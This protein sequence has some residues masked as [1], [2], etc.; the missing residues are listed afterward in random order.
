MA[1][2]VK[3]AYLKKYILQTGDIC[4]GLGWSGVLENVFLEVLH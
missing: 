1:K 4:S 3:F 2:R